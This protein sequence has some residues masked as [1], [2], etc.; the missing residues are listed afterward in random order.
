MRWMFLFQNKQ[1]TRPS[2]TPAENTPGE[3]EMATLDLTNWGNPEATISW[4]Y[5]VGPAG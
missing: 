1:Q 2:V 5:N 3:R 4:H